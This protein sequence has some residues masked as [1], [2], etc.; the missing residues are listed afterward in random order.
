MSA[1]TSASKQISQRESAA[2]KENIPLT[3]HKKAESWASTFAS[4]RIM[5]ATGMKFKEVERTKFKT[6]AEDL[7]DISNSWLKEREGYQDTINAFQ[8]KSLGVASFKEKIQKCNEGRDGLIRARFE[9]AEA[10]IVKG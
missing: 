9:A 8:N 10:E 1:P 6:L 4:K 7:L 5:A 3:E 2:R